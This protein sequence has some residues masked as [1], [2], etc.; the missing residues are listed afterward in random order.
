M[1]PLERDA[2]GGFVCRLAGFTSQ[3]ATT[4]D[5][6]VD[7]RLGTATGN[8]FFS[9]G[10]DVNVNGVKLSRLSSLFGGG[11]PQEQAVFRL[12]GRGGVH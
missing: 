1:D 12:D 2:S 10:H 5:S 7:V 6:S 11:Y 4:C 9:T 8:P 3:A